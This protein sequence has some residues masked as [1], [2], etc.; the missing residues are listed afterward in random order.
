MIQNCMVWLEK[1]SGEMFG[2]L[3]KF[4]QSEIFYPT[5]A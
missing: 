2:K 1:I 4:P 3:S 5:L